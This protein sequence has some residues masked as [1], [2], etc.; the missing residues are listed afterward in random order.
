MVDFDVFCSLRY[1]QG[2]GAF[3][4]LEFAAHEKLVTFDGHLTWQN[5][6][7]RLLSGVTALVDSIAHLHCPLR[8]SSSSDSFCSYSVQTTGLEGQFTVNCVCC[9]R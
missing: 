6:R 7:N 3:A 5:K 8:F 4:K 2:S 9:L 1:N